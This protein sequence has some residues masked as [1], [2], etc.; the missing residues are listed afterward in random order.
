M[1]CTAACASSLS[2]QFGL[3]TIS[4]SSKTRSEAGGEQNDVTC[5]HQVRS[6][7][8]RGKG[9]Q[10]QQGS[11]GRGGERGVRRDRRQ[12]G[13]KQAGP[14]GLLPDLPSAQAQGARPPQPGERQKDKKPTEKPA[15]L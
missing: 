7:P 3:D 1:L 8:G 13:E 6:R 9:G 2:F 5:G 12:R 14:P 10:P 11:G 4:A 15:P